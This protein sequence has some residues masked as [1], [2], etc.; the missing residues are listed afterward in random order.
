MNRSM[1]V[2]REVAVKEGM[3]WE[4]YQLGTGGQVLA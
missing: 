1:A 4:C 2:R 3:V